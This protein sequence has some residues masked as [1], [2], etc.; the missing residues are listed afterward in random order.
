MRALYTVLR[1]K[2]HAATPTFYYHLYAINK[3][4]HNLSWLTLSFLPCC[5]HIH[6]PRNKCCFFL[7]TRTY[8]ILIH[9]RCWR[10]VQHQP[11]LKQEAV[12]AAAG[13]RRAWLH[14][15]AGARY[16]PHR[17]DGPLLRLQDRRRGGLVRLAQARQT[18]LQEQVRNDRFAAGSYRRI[19]RQLTTRGVRVSDLNYNNSTTPSGTQTTTHHSRKLCLFPPL[20]FAPLFFA[21]PISWRNAPS[22][23][24][25]PRPPR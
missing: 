3:N 4:H 22:P 2:A 7:R 1:R 25:A 16:A 20:F 23:P 21:P 6:P 14:I 9:L 15:Y 19:L 11:V 5:G 8:E 10:N 18:Q 12:A 13:V 17:D 24:P